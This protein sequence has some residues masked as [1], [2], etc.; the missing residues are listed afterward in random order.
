MN[1]NRQQQQSRRYQYRS[2]TP[3]ANTPTNSIAEI[4]TLTAARN[5]IETL[6]YYSKARK[7]LVQ[8]YSGRHSDEWFLMSL[9][10]CYHILLAHE[11]GISFIYNIH[12]KISYE[13]VVWNHALLQ[14]VEKLMQFNSGCNLLSTLVITF[15]HLDYA[16]SLPTVIISAFRNNNSREYPLLLKNT[17][18]EYKENEQILSPLLKFDWRSSS[19][20]SCL[21]LKL[22]IDIIPIHLLTDIFSS[23]V[24]NFISLAKTDEFVHGLCSIISK[25]NTDDYETIYYQI[26]SNLEFFIFKSP[27]YLLVLSLADFG[28][29]QKRKEILSECIET[30]YQN[31]LNRPKH[32]DTLIKHLLYLVPAL[33]RKGFM[34]NIVEKLKYQSD[35]IV[36]QQLYYEAFVMNKNFS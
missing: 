2:P 18:K 34:D 4:S 3:Q 24:P 10:K 22:I 33:D 14:N 28:T 9:I 23:I 12:M 11:A 26:F 30:S 6:I 21:Y 35:A 25:V 7:Q 15:K 1:T 27:Q 13:C 31:M 5:K 16:A 20:L 8:L 32:F 36:T 29:F 17:I 19:S